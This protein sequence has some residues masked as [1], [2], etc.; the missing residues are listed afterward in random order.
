MLLQVPWLEYLDA[1]R[2]LAKQVGYA[3][4]LATGTGVYAAYRVFYAL[5]L[6]PLRSIPGPFL[7]RITSWRADMFV[8]MG[9]RARKAREDY[10]A[11]GDIQ[12]YQPNAISISNPEHIH[13]VLGS[14]KFTK[15]KMYDG[16]RLVPADS[17]GAT[18]DDKVASLRRRQIGPYLSTTYLAKMESTILEHGYLALREKWDGLLEKSDGGEVKVNYQHHFL[19][20]AFDIIGTLA[21]GRGFGALKNDDSTVHKWI[22]EALLYVG[23]RGMLPIFRV[24]PF[25]LLLTPFKRTSDEY[26]NYAANC[27]SERRQLLDDLEAKGGL[28]NKPTDLL[29]GFIQAEDPESKIRL[30]PGEVHAETLEMLTAGTETVSNTLMWTLNLLMLYPECYRRAVDEVRSAFDKDHLV[31]FKDAKVHL[32]YLEACFYESQRLIPFAGG[33]I[34]RITPKEGVA[35]DGHFIP[36]GTEINCNILGAHY[37]KK[38]W[39]DPYLYDPARFLDSDEATRNLFAFGYG[40]HACPGRQLAWVEMLT[41]MANMLK[42][43]D[44][45]LP[46]DYTEHGPNVLDHRGYPKLLDTVSLI[47]V[48]PANIER[49]CVVV[50]SKRR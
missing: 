44:F 19:H 27:I 13:T 32:P 49:D 11:Y 31:V 3:R 17:I 1:L 16:M 39:K 29:Q 38:Y 46:D 35:F 6:S 33:H 12:V 50:V 30:T 37:N 28:D 7:A 2:D 14:S 10:E 22:N 47:G 43:Y 9:A 20:S 15:G 23:L 8:F 25:S 36:A 24:F 48:L 5:Y 40:V 4:L 42:D 45:R 34:P 18:M 26:I 21:F 41:T